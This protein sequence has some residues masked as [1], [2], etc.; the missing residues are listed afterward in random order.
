MSEFHYIT[1]NGHRFEV[2]LLPAAFTLFSPFNSVGHKCFKNYFYF[3]I[4]RSEG[5]EGVKVFFLV[6]DRSRKWFSTDQHNSKLISEQPNGS[7]LSAK[8]SK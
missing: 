7:G 1:S 2:I 6:Y 4:N 3:E 8:K 5:D